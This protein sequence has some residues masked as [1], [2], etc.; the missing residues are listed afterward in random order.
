MER[1]HFL[2]LAAAALSAGG[3]AGCAQNAA[4]TQ[5][6][7]PVAPPAAAP[8]P[9]ALSFA[10]AV[11]GI[12]AVIARDRADPLIEAAAYPRLYHH[13]KSTERAVVLFHGFTNC[14]QQFDELARG[15][16]AR[17]C[18]VYVPRVPL[19]GYRDR[20]TRALGALTVPQLRGSATEAYTFVRGLGEKTAALGLSM[21]G[22]MALYLAQTQDIDHA[23]PVS[24]FLMPIHIPDRVGLVAMR[25]IDS[26]PDRYVWW[27]PRVKEKCL[28]LYAYPGFPT[29]ALAQ[30][31]FFGNGVV[32]AANGGTRPRARLCT[33]V[34]NLNE[35]AVNNNVTFELMDTWKKS[36][37][38][39]DRVV[40]SGL[41]EP[42]HDIIDPTTFPQAR[43]LVYPKLEAI[44]MDS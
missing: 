13:G 3:L 2:H 21:G 9:Q 36:G 18:N 38:H 26:R 41:G 17:G 37:A 35:S 11:R 12:E 28:P 44:V 24:P 15:F 34:T 7:S 22:S 19:H 23:I 8:A 6:A 16:H 14:P 1:T 43:T 29:H 30:L 5:S 42:R 4:P 20:L 33:L 27:D 31:V 10:D 32:K 25:T 39:Y 40:L